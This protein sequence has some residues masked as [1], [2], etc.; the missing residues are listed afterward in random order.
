MQT[1]NRVLN[2]LIGWI[3]PR[4]S[5]FYSLLFMLTALFVS[6]SNLSAQAVQTTPPPSSAAAT[7]ATPPVSHVATPSLTLWNLL[8][9]AE[10]VLVPMVLLS[11]MVVGLVIY[12]FFWLS[13]A[14]V[15]SDTFLA[16]SD[17]LIAD[18]N[19][20]ALLDLCGRRN[21]M[22]AHAL[23]RV[24]LFAQENP[25]LGVEA[26]EKVAEASAGSEVSKLSQPNQ[27][28]MDLGVMAPM[29]GLLGT[30]YGILRA[31]GNLSSDATP[32]RTMLLAGGVSQALVATAMGLAVGLIAMFFSAYFKS[33]VQILVSHFE[34]TLTPLLV[35]TYE[36]LHSAKSRDAVREYPTNREYAMSVEQ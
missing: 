11:L 36:C 31:F 21:E 22:A 28:L 2:R 23:S 32:M 20:E 19:L 26:W 9:A 12:N 6:V 35:R 24:V 3:D 27:L 34:N 1:Q 18:R 8:V 15:A 17:R 29:I 7:S 14:R 5:V 25:R 10:W 16:L 4:K 33:K 13:R 30:V